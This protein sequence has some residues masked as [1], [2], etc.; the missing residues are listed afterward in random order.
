VFQFLRNVGKIT[1]YEWL[2]TTWEFNV[3]SQYLV[4]QCFLVNFADFPGKNMV[5]V[6]L[7]KSEYQFLLE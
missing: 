1:S 2:M 7:Y 5:L 3:S 6:F 4:T